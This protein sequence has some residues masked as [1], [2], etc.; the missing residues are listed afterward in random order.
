MKLFINFFKFTN[1]CL[2]AFLLNSP[3][4]VDKFNFIFINKIK[5]KTEQ[6]GSD[7]D[8][9]GSKSSLKDR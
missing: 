3:I 8:L 1:D 2:L 6:T 7:N 9:F 5:L 4:I